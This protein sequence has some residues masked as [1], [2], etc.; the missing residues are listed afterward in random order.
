MFMSF[1]LTPEGGFEGLHVTNENL[2]TLGCTRGS[3][4]GAVKKRLRLE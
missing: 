1:F 4:M 3:R 2:G